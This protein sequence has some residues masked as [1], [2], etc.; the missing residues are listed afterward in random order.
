MRL[1][2]G[3]VAQDQKLLPGNVIAVARMDAYSSF[4]G[5]LCLGSYFWLLKHS[6]CTLSRCGCAIYACSLRA[7]AG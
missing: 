6:I 3:Q 5:R 2:Q 7:G 1:G 4:E